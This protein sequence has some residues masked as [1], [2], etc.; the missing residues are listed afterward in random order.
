MLIILTLA[1]VNVALSEL[2]ERDWLN[3]WLQGCVL[4]QDLYS[5]PA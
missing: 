1:L 2:C 4:R 5:V 3:A